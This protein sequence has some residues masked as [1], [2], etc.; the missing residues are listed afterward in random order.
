MVNFQL[1]QIGTLSTKQMSKQKRG[2]IKNSK[3]RQLNVAIRTD[4]FI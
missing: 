1:A 4:T 3:T 2:L